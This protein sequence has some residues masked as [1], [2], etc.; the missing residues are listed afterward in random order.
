[1]AELV[2]APIDEFIEN[3]LR[4]GYDILCGTVLGSKTN[5]CQNCSGQ[6]FDMPPE[7]LMTVVNDDKSD[8]RLCT[9]T[10]SNDHC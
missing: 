8:Q 2:R 6:A 1:M 9:L 4:T 7:G 10:N 3:D 5:G